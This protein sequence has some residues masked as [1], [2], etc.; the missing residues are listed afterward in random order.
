VAAVTG[1]CDA[2][3]LSPEGIDTTVLA[4]R[5]HRSSAKRRPSALEQRLVARTDSRLLQA[6]ARLAT[7]PLRT[8]VERPELSAADREFLVEALAPDVEK[9]RHFSGRSFSRWSL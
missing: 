1:L 3:G 7:R 6:A 5:F 8:R 9:L 4:R 2:V